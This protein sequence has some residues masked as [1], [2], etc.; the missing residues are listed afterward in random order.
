MAKF[1][2][3]IKRFA[4]E[5]EGATLVEYALAL[6]LISLVAGAIVLGQGIGHVFGNV[7][8]GVDQITISNPS[9]YR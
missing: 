1:I 3:A 4:R 2:T 9:R 6:A 7:R 8:A 5:E